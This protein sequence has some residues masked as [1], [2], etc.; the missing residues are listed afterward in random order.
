MAA[1]KHGLIMGITFPFGFRKRQSQIAM[2]RILWTD[3]W[4]QYAVNKPGRDRLFVRTQCRRID[5]RDI[6]AHVARPEPRPPPWR[7][8]HTPQ[9]SADTQTEG[10]S[11]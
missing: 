9:E 6:C 8:P 4:A 1:Q 3:A 7:Y 11:G 5:L 2:G 10:R